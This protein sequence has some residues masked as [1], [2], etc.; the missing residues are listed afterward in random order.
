MWGTGVNKIVSIDSSSSSF[1][2]LEKNKHGI[3]R[4]CQTVYLFNTVNT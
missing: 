3:L 2:F 4:L 1:F